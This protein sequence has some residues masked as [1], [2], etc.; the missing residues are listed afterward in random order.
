MLDKAGISVKVNFL[1]IGK[2]GGADRIGC[3]VACLLVFSEYGRT[4]STRLLIARPPVGDQPMRSVIEEDAGI[5][6][7]CLLLRNLEQVLAAK[8]AF[9]ENAVPKLNYIQL[10]RSASFRSCSNAN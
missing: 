5:N 8:Q 10:S 9:A 4:Q 6:Q 7:K 3:F 1:T 2:L